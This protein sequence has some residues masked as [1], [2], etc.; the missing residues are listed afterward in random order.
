MLRRR[1][2]VRFA[3]QISLAGVLL[4]IL[5]I[6]ILVWMIT[7]LNKI[8]I[9][10]SFAPYGIMQLINDAEVDEN[11][12]IVHST[13][14]DLL[15]QDGGWLQSLDE[16]GNVLQS[17][18]TPEDVPERYEPGQLIDLWQG[19]HPSPYIIGLWIHSK[20]AHTYILLY[21]ISASSSQYLVPFIEQAELNEDSI[22][23]P[24]T[25]EMELA[26]MGG[27]IQVINSE[28]NEIASWNKPA[29]APSL[30][31]L[32]ELALRSTYFDEYGTV[33][34]TD[35]DE[36]TGYTWILQAPVT[37][38]LHHTSIIPNVRSEIQVMLISLVMFIAGAL[39]VF[40]V[41]AI[42][43]ANRFVKPVLDIIDS[44]Q[45]IA[46]GSL[47]QVSFSKQKQKKHLFKEVMESIHK[48]AATLRASKDAEQKTQL[49]REEWIAGVTHDMKTPLA[50]IQ[51]YAH[52][53]AADK[54]SWTDD[55]V[56]S[57]AATIL[58]KSQYMDQLMEDLALTYRL[59]SGE[60]PV[61]L[62]QHS[63][64]ALLQEAVV[65]ASAHPAFSTRSISCT[66][67]KQEIFGKVHAPWFERIID[68]LIANS[69]LHNSNDTNIT[70]ELEPLAD[71]GWC[72]S[73]I[74]DGQGMDEQTVNQLFR[75]YYR[76]TNTEQ[77]VAG[78]GLGMAI[79]KELVQALDGEIQVDSKPGH[80]TT[81]RLIWK[82]P[83]S[84]GR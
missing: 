55:E 62:D 64:G 59:R 5:A 14:L 57:F 7:E 33:F 61:A 31:T 21:G 23:L 56:R 48:L 73:V 2:T 25:V 34:Q 39:I 13:M 42:G 8:D 27:W 69:L 43:Y 80:G 12:L 37:E 17:F 79:T 50:S 67:P 53:L 75:R 45:R 24:E 32:S 6:A 20:G 78:S 54:Y 63:I 68:N 28:G 76:G 16:Q 83:A 30:Y 41:L 44:I 19:K 40:I 4:A 52:M 65:R 82:H 10:R 36:Q 22:L 74:D 47:E 29:H 51:G 15:E 49:Y 81:I 84:L 18:F 11:G 71:D 58:E 35:Y 9:K 26:N 1:L 77:S 3:L 70:I 72:I 66:L 46:V 38:K 60:L